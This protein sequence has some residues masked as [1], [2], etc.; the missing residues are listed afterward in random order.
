MLGFLLKLFFPGRF[1]P[2]PK[3]QKTPN[4][5]TQLSTPPTVNVFATG[6]FEHIS[7]YDLLLIFCTNRKAAKVAL[8]IKGHRAL[9][10][11]SQGR[12]EQAMYQAW[13]GKEAVLHIFADIDEDPQAQFII[14]P[15]LEQGFSEQGV[16]LESLLMEIAQM[17]DEKRR[18]IAG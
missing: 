4:I 3:K 16:K 11:V 12:I 5:K 13:M 7:L 18:M 15:H 9:M 17:L 10:I 1:K 6:S 8:R 14:K 2:K